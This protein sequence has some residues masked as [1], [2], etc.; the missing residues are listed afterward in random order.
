MTPEGK[1]ELDKI[2]DVRG[3]TLPVHEYLAE[4]NPE[5]LKRYGNLA[6]YTI[7]G[8][9]EGRALD[10]KT[11][12]LVLVGVTTA[13]KGDRE[14]V[15]WASKRAIQNGATWKE[16]YEAAFMAALPAGIP[17][18][19]ATCRAFN[20]MKKGEGWVDQEVPEEAANT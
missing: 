14:G 3:Y 8:E 9:E 7:F 1:A 18:F 15:E 10:L 13:I 5:F 16:V 11:R 2:R 20:E 19:E 12:F 17:A 6:S 4:L